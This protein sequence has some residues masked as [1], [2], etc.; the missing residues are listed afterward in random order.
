VKI[1]TNLINL[2]ELMKTTENFSNFALTLFGAAILIFSGCKK[3][4]DDL[5]T[6]KDADGNVYKTVTIG[7]QEWFAENLRTTKY[8]NGDA[9]PTGH[10]KAAWAGL[11]TGAYTV[12]PHSEIDGLNS[13]TEVLGVYGALYNYYAVKTGKL[14]PAGWRIPTDGDWTILIDNAGG[15]GIAGG[16]LKSTRTAPVAHPRWESP[17]LNATDEYGFSAIPAG[18]MSH[19]GDFLF[20]GYGSYWWSSTEEQIGSWYRAMIWE[21]AEVVRPVVDKRFGYSVRCIKE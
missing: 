2:I 10:N 17:N 5:N 9:I 8:R 3:D 11:T 19:E 14:C 1:F 21:N 4:D 18:L 7:N 20:N 12:Y 15:S 13:G 6:V 16:K